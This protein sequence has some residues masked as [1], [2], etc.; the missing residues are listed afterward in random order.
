MFLQLSFD[1]WIETDE[2]GQFEVQSTSISNF[3]FEDFI[4]FQPLLLP[5]MDVLAKFDDI[6]IRIYSKIG[7]LGMEIME[8]RQMRDKLLPRFLSGKLSVNLKEN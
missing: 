2:M 6:A 3:Q 8:L 4:D 5:S 1:R 7:I